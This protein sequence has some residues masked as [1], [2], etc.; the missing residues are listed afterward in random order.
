MKVRSDV[1]AFHD[2][3]FFMYARAFTQSEGE[4]LFWRKSNNY[5]GG[6]DLS[7]GL[8]T[9]IIVVKATSLMAHG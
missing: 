1:K 7:N 2:R 4:P 8:P 9:R 3:Q 6:Q 5:P